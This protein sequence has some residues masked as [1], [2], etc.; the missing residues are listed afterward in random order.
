MRAWSRIPSAERAFCCGWRFAC[1]N[2][3]RC[4]GKPVGCVAAAEALVTS[5]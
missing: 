4:G 1:V 3:V 2:A 5:R